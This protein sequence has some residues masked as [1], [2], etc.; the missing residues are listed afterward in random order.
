[1]LVNKLKNIIVEGAEQRPILLDISYQPTGKKKPIV[2]FLHGFKGFKDWGC[3]GLIGSHFAQASF[4]FIACNFSHN[5]TTPDAPEEFGDLE[6]FG[7]NN[8]SKELF[9]INA[10]LDWLENT[11]IEMAEQ[12]FDRS[13]IHLIGHSRGGA[14]GIIQAARDQRIKKLVT[15]AAVSRLDYLWLRHPEI[16]DPW[17]KAGVHYILNGR[18][19]QEMPLYFQLYEDFIVHQK[20]FDIPT[21]CRAMQQ[22]ML[23][24]QGTEDPAV[25]V[26]AAKDLAAWHPHAELVLIE[27]ADH[28]FGGRHPYN[29]DDIPEPAKTLADKSIEFLLP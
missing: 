25:P 18:T 14:I 10:V 21:A 26:S 28:V 20:A 27:G 29:S 5:G 3:W 11:S 16:I 24:I 7:Q 19:K 13:T 12:E 6:A 17:K 2:L 8:F 4:V 9:D 15:W 1:M 22:P 23:I